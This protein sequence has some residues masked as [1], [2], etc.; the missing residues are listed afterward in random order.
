VRI[1]FVSKQHLPAPGGA[2][3]TT[4]LL[5]RELTARGH[6]VTVI[7]REAPRPSDDLGYGVVRSFSPLGELV[8]SQPDVVVVGGYDRFRVDEALAALRVAAPRPTL[9]HLHDA[10]ATDGRL[11][12][13]PAVAV[14]RYVA[15]RAP[16]AEVIPPALDAD[17]C[18]TDS[19]R[20]VALLVNPHPKKGAR[21]ALALARARPDVQ[22]AFVRCWSLSP[23]YLR[24]LTEECRRLGNVELRP[25]TTDQRA[26]YADARVLLVPS[27]YPEAYGRVAAEA[28]VSG[29]PPIAAS[30]GGLPE[31]VGDGGV[32]VDPAGGEPAWLEAFSD[33][34]DDEG[35]YARLS[36]R[37]LRA[38]ER[39][40]L[41]PAATTDRFERV[42]ERLAA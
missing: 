21:T 12:G 8:G 39:Q 16:G 3:V 19:S 34:W 42:L 40:E 33:V 4:H 1:A 27:I 14:S 30:I 26:L 23:S 37:A 2:Q 31:A 29:I 10:G 28:Q 24:W 38:A 6:E 7:A 25:A 13:V 32:L 18:R 20:A 11:A 17:A 15:D 9:V 22:F 5:A 35:T 41:T 36:E